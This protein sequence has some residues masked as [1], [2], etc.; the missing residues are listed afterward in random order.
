MREGQATEPVRTSCRVVTSVPC[1]RSTRHT[2]PDVPV[3]RVAT[4]G[5][6]GTL[7]GDVL[8]LWCSGRQHATCTFAPPHRRAGKSTPAVGPSDF[9]P[10]EADVN[11]PPSGKRCAL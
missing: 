1:G 7:G 10:P 2:S 5:Y 8:R 6:R 4:S 11:P 9:P 3:S